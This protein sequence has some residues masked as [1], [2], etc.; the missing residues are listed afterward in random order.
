[1]KPVHLVFDDDLRPIC[2]TFAGRHG[3][4]TR[5]AGFIVLAL[6]VAWFLASIVQLAQTRQELAAT[7]SELQA[8]GRRQPVA[9]APK[10]ALRTEQRRAWNQVVR[11]LNTPW[12]GLLAALE[13]TTP[14]DVALVSI[15]PD[16]RQGSVRIQ[17][18]AKA[19]EVL[20]AYAQAL[21]AVALFADVVPLKHETN[22]QD[23]NRPV[24]LTLNLQLRPP[25][26]VATVAG[27]TR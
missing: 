21:K 16:A 4:P 17:A 1:M 2:S 24:R 10:P 3:G 26:A 11:Q 7:E 5:L 12:G 9:A 25:K 22:E 13:A 8:L 6:A 19:L 18:E 15:E 27:D 14:D 20:L 23:P